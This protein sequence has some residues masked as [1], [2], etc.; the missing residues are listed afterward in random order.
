MNFLGMGPMELMMI[1]VLALIVFGPGKLPEI[2]GQVGRMVRD[3]RRTTSELSSE[4]SRTLSL[5]IEERKTAQA[6][7]PVA[8]EAAPYEPP[9]AEE[10]VGAIQPVP[11]PV[12]VEP[13]EAPLV[14]TTTSSAP[15]ETAPAPEPVVASKRR[16]RDTGIEPPY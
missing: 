15:V 2:A 9:P 10:V 3:F 6:P 8:A 16:T 7:A 12:A 5:E 14:V 11:A 1:L 13:A 4:F